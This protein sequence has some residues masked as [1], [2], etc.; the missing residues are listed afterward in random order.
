M[1]ARHA[2]SCG[3]QVGT[4]YRKRE[5]FWDSC[6]S[7]ALNSTA[8]LLFCCRSPLCL[9][10]C[11]AKVYESS[12]ETLFVGRQDA[13]QRST[14]VPLAD[15]MAG[16]DASQMTVGYRGWGGVGRWLAGWAGG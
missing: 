10:C 5:W 9:P 8:S 16:K 3:A 7:T 14:L 13:M 12:T 4:L 11:A 15:F 2:A 6:C 1:A